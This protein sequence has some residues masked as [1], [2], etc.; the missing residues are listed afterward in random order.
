VDVPR[1]PSQGAG[2]FRS[3][4]GAYDTP[5]AKGQ[6]GPGRDDDEPPWDRVQPPAYE[7]FGPGD[8]PLDDAVDPAKARQS[9]EEQAIKLLSE[10]LGAERISES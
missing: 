2:R 5:S 6:Y 8:E 10:Q 7:G 1:A 3:A 4:G 9:S